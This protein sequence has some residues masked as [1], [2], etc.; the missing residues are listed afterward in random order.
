MFDLPTV[1]EAPTSVRYTPAWGKHV[2]LHVWY[3]PIPT[4]LVI[5][6]FSRRLV[7][8]LA[9]LFHDQKGSVITPPS[10]LMGIL[11]IHYV[12]L[13]PETCYNSKMQA[14]FQF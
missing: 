5:Q 4:W 8:W 3:I 7:K 9:H 10:F 1:S 11:H 2:Y 6:M 14:L 12:L 13:L